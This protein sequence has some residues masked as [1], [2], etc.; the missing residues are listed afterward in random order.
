[1]LP[2]PNSFTADPATTMEVDSGAPTEVVERLGTVIDGV[3]AAAAADVGREDDV[4]WMS[5]MGSEEDSSA[6]PLSCTTDA[7]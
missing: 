2:I 6:I 7:G 1:M 3:E 4:A 5:S